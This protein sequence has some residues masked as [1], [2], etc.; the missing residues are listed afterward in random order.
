MIHGDRWQSQ[1]T[2][3]L[4]AFQQGRVR[5]L[6]ATDLASRGIHVE[7]IAQVINYDLPQL[8]EDFIHR[9]WAAQDAQVD[10][11][12]PLRCSSITSGRTCASWNGFSE[13]RSS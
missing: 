8:P 3:A 11:A 10:K 4:T 1:R 13:S 12:W 6:V 9:A 2:A 7:D 5:V